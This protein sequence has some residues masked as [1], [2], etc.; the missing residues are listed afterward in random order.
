MAVDNTGA[1]HIEL[2]VSQ[3]ASQPSQQVMKR[4]SNECT[5]CL[6]VQRQVCCFLKNERVRTATAQQQQSV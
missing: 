5:R 1:F 3:S 2:P 4:T 6:C